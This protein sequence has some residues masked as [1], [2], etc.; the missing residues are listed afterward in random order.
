[1]KTPVLSAIGFAVK[2]P[3]PLIN[4]HFFAVQFSHKNLFGAVAVNLWAVMTF[5]LKYFPFFQ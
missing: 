2:R 4:A 1:M 5:N 3:V